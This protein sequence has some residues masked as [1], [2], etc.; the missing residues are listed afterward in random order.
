MVRPLTVTGDRVL[1]RHL[2]H[3]LV[4]NAIRHNV[5]GGRVE[6]STGPAGLLVRTASANPDGGLTL[7]VTFP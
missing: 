4:G 2:V 6:L 7:Q 1:L 5:P 3:N